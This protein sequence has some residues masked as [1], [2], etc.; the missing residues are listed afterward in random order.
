MQR[1]NKGF[2]GDLLGEI[3]PGAG[4]LLG[5]LVGPLG[6]IVGGGVGKGLGGLARKLPFK[7]GGVVMKKKGKKAA[8]P[9]KGSTAMKQRMAK[10]RAMRK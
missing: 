8:M 5:S 1:Q 9:A 10:L 6:T 7:K 2:F 4:S 3:L